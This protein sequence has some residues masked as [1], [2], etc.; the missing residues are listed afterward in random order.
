MAILWMD[1]F[2]LYDSFADAAGGGWSTQTVGTNAA[3]INLTG[4]RTGGGCLDLHDNNTRVAF[5]LPVTQGFGETRIYA[6]SLKFVTNFLSSGSVPIITFLADNSSINGALRMTVDS[7]GALR[8][9]DG[10]PITTT[11]DFVFNLEQWYRVELKIKASTVATSSDT[12]T[13]SVDCYIDGNL[14]A[15]FAANIVWNSSTKTPIVTMLFGGSTSNGHTLFDD[16]VIYDTTG[17]VNNSAPMGDVVITTL[18]PDGEGSEQDWTANT[19]TAE[20]AIDDAAGSSDGDSTY[21]SSSTVGDK[22]EFTLGDL[23]DASASILGVQARVK[24]KKTDAGTRTYRNYLLSNASAANGDSIS[25]AT[26]Y[27]WMIGK[28]IEENPDGGAAWS[29][30]SVNALEVGLETLT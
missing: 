11:T 21:I 30:A 15:S 16:L 13:G 19:G 17:S 26:D 2:D 18:R 3:A 14:V 9:L 28:P 27:D 22:S 6:F 5:N 25:P 8:F 4:G 10:F 24:S 23:S 20:G 1:G 29:D 7:G 12:R